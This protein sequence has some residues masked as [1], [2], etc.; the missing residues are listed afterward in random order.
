MPETLEDIVSSQR[1]RWLGHLARMTDERIPKKIL[2]GWLPNRR[3][4]HGPKLRWQDKVRSDMKRFH[5]DE[6][7][8]FKIARVWSNACTIKPFNN[9]TFNTGQSAE[10]QIA[11]YVCNT[12]AG[13]F[14]RP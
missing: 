1:L 10:Q 12:C 8:W 11:F 3:P 13:S 9:V 7:N 14:R 2:F 5:I 6:K 4:G